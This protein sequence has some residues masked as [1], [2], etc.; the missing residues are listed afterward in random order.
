LQV[1]LKNAGFNAAK[2]LND[3]IMAQMHRTSG[4]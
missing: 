4:L 2:D 3:R 1:K